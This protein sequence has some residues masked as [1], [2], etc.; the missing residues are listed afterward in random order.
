MVRLRNK[1]IP[2]LNEEECY[3]KQCKQPIK[4]EK[5][6]SPSYPKFFVLNS[7]EFF[8]SECKG[9]LPPFLFLPF[10]QMGGCFDSPHVIQD[11]YDFVVY[12]QPKLHDK[13]KKRDEQDL[14]NL[15]IGEINF[16]Y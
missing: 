4:K 1:E 5:A 13:C 9:R 3:V 6:L 11:E 10:R 14:N 7:L 2:D 12:Y 15:R 16:V 8:F